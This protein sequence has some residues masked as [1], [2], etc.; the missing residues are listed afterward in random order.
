MV[1][2]RI[3]SN[4]LNGNLTGKGKKRA[5]RDVVEKSEL[6]WRDFSEKSPF[7]DKQKKQNIMIEEPDGYSKDVD[8]R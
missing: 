1:E 2:E 6:L 5:P 8:I 7:A 3:Q 4:S